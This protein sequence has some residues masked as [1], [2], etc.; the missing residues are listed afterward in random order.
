[1]MVIADHA[2][3]AIVANPAGLPRSI[4]RARPVSLPYDREAL[5]GCRG[6]ARA[7]SPCRGHHKRLANRQTKAQGLGLLGR[8]EKTNR[9]NV[10]RSGDNLW[11][12]TP[13]N[14]AP[15]TR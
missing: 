6:H 7:T 1:M 10:V 4:L 2:P 9:S 15:V 13:H 14:V 8:G 12:R 11:P 3:T 5:T